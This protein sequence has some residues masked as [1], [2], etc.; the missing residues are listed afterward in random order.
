ML[1]AIDIEF[2]IQLPGADSHL[3]WSML[4]KEVSRSRSVGWEGAK[5]WFK[6]NTK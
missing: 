3:C 1:V 5:Q 4:C 6:P 2:K